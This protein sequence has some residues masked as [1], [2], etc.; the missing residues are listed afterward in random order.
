M[1][2]NNKQRLKD[3]IGKMVQ[4]VIVDEYL[5]K[6]NDGFLDIFTMTDYEFYSKDEYEY[7]LINIHYN[8]GAGNYILILG[9]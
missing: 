7:K 6:Y 4:V 8:E 2:I 3:L 1:D 5:Y 9:E